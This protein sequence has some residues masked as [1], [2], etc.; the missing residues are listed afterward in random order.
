[1]RHRSKTKIFS[2][3]K[4]ARVAM[5]KNLATSVILYERVRTTEAKAKAVRPIVE[6]LITT[7]KVKSLN[8]KRALDRVLPDKKAVKKI[9]EVLGPRYKDRN[10]GYTRIIKIE[11]RQ[12][13]GAHIAQVEFV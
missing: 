3:S 8:T 7:G 10:G 2:R 4:A 5:L 6:R 12:G 13:D 1:M 9:L 11:Q